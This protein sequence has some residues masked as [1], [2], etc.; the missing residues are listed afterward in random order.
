MEKRMQERFLYKE[1][2][3]IFRHRVRSTGFRGYATSP[4][5]VSFHILSNI[6]GKY[7]VASKYY[8]A[9]IDK[10]IDG[11]LIN[12]VEGIQEFRNVDY[13]FVDSNHICVAVMANGCDLSLCTKPD[14]DGI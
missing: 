11:I 7:P 5:I 3:A 1:L 6:I 9:I 10:A 2:K 8:S 4:F 14:S 12:T 13:M